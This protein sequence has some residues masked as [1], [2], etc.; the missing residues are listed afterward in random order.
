MWMHWYLEIFIHR[1]FNI[2]WNRPF[3]RQLG[4]DSIVVY[5]VYVHVFVWELSLLLCLFVNFEQ[6]KLKKDNIII[7]QQYLRKAVN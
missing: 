7:L 1:K 5:L 3:G 6:Q 2:N 4:K